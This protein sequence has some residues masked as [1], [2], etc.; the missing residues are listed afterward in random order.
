VRFSPPSFTFPPGP[1]ELNLISESALILK[2]ALPQEAKAKQTFLRSYSSKEAWL[3]SC[4]PFAK[5]LPCSPILIALPQLFLNVGDFVPEWE[6]RPA[7]IR[8]QSFD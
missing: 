5:Q 1:C 6:I 8:G 2:I 7:S 4:E 3:V